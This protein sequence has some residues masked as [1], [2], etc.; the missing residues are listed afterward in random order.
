MPWPWQ[1]LEEI[2]IGAC[3]VVKSQQ[4]ESGDATM[5]VA[6]PSISYRR[7]ISFLFALC[8]SCCGAFRRLLGKT[9]MAKRWGQ[10]KKQFP[11][12]GYV[13]YNMLWPDRLGSRIATWSI[14]KGANK[15]GA[16]FWQMFHY[17]RLVFILHLAS[18]G[19]RYLMR[20]DASCH[21]GQ[22]LCSFIHFSCGATAFPGVL[23]HEPR[24][25]E[26]SENFYEYAHC[27][28]H[29]WCWWVAR[30]LIMALWGLEK[31]S[32]WVV[33]IYIEASEIAVSLGILQGQ[34]L[35]S[36][37]STWALLY[38]WH[39]LSSF[40]FRGLAFGLPALLQDQSERQDM[41]VKIK[42]DWFMFVGTGRMQ[43]SMTW[44]G[45]KFWFVKWPIVN[46]L[47]GAF[48]PGASGR[49]PFLC[50]QRS[51]LG[52]GGACWEGLLCQPT[53]T[54]G[55]SEGSVFWQVCCR[56]AKPTQSTRTIQKESVSC[57]KEIRKGVE[58]IFSDC[59]KDYWWESRQ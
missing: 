40:Q 17:P 10:T 42:E 8:S 48:R 55:H 21:K 4:G 1:F 52:E 19:Y 22:H 37:S 15:P 29:R 16:L 51:W 24:P 28:R 33:F 41:D 59:F 43:L 7:C 44:R 58:N 26:G 46:L 32:S 38:S 35:H 13:Q 49:W 31:G 20:L 34:V 47:Y 30:D 11:K 45:D 6:G 18:W 56:I 12:L 50:C 27:G 25:A 57:C 36:W 3:L 23:Q 53:S 39:V 54:S 5:E 14:Q 9:K 2:I